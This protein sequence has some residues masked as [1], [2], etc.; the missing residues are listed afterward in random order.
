MRFGITSQVLQDSIY[1]LASEH[2][3]GIEVTLD[4]CSLQHMISFEVKDRQIF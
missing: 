4:Y 2:T 1:E 3:C